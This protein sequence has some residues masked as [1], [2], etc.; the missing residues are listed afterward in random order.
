MQEESSGGMP[1]EESGEGW[2]AGDPEEVLPYWN[3]Y[4]MLR[5]E[6]SFPCPHGPKEGDC[7][8]C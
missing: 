7:C 2:K 3:R 1:P 8:N 5:G 6:C 4:L